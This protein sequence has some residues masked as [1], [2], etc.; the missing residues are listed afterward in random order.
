MS[1][2]KMLLSSNYWILNKDIVKELGWDVAG[3]LSVLVE[4]DNMFDDEWF[5][6]TSET[7][8]EL[9][10]TTTHIQSKCIKELKKRGM[11]EQKNK[12]IPMK[13]YFKLNYEEIQKQVFKNFKN[14][15]SKILETSFSKIE[16]NKE[17]IINKLDKETNINIDV[18]DIFNYWIEKKAGI[19]HRKL[20]DEMITAINSKIK[21][22]GKDKVI[23]SIKRLS[24]AYNDKNYYYKHEWSLVNFIKQ[25]NGVPNWFDEGQLYNDYK[26]TNKNSK[27]IKSENVNLLVN[28]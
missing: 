24:E 3:M 14:C 10:G 4:A 15:N 6:Q 9:T 17:S 12:G 19:H 8:E 20:T 23:I 28:F 18:Q 7:I 11:L 25:S 21:K 27:E 22:Y 26:K 16:K 2:K 13:R 5:F 1:I